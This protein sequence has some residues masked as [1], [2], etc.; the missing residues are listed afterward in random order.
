MAFH[1]RVAFQA[2]S[3]RSRI[4]LPLE[5]MSLVQK[6]PRVVTPLLYHIT[7]RRMLWGDY[8]KLYVEA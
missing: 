5:N 6:L 7:F 1:N 8:T 3:Q 4:V 2:S